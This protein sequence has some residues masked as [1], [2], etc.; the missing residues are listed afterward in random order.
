M[1]IEKQKLKTVVLALAL[2]AGMSWPANAFAQRER[3]G[4]LGGYEEPTN[5]RGLLGRGGSGGLYGSLGLQNFG[6]NQDNITLQNFGVAVSLFGDNGLN[7]Q[8]FGGNQDDITFQNFGQQ[9]PLGSG[10]FILLATSA[11]YAA[12]KSRKNNK[13]Q[14]KSLK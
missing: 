6:E 9:V 5:N 2:L 3:G 1:R 11:G 10:L 7:L 12:L 4:L 8:N 14:T 13:K